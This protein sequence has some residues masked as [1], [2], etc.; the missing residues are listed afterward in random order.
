MEIL[1]GV[2]D[3]AAQILL[4]YP[5]CDSCL[6]RQFA[7]L[8]RGLSNRERGRAI[9]TLLLMECVR[10][11]SVLDEGLL[12]A[13][14]K[15]GFRPALEVSRERHLDVEV[16]R[17]YICNGLMEADELE[18]WADRVV[19]VLRHYEFDTFQL[20]CRLESEMLA[21]E[22]E[23]RAKFKLEYGES[24]KGE[25][26]REVGKLVQRRTGK[27]FDPRSPDVLA[28]VDV[29]R[30]RVEVEAR[31]LFVYGRYRKL[32][33]GIPQSV[34]L[35]SSCRGRGCPECNWTG[36]K[37]PDSIEEY[38]SLPIVEAAEGRG[39]KFHGAGREDLDV[40]TLGSG[41]P[42]V[43][44]VK[45]PRRRKLDLKEL[46][47]EI[48]KRAGGKVEVFGLR[49]ADRRTV[50]RIKR[51]AEI[52]TKVYR[53][54]ATFDREIK[55]EELRM[56]EDA[57]SNVTIKQRTPLRVLHRRADRVRSKVVYGVRA[58]KLGENRVE[59]LVECQGGLYVKEFVTGDGGRT[60]PSVAEILGARVLEVTVDVLGVEEVE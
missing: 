3:K 37:Y 47:E 2:L 60:R 24:I 43:V 44:E 41:R 21:R 40:R 42:F 58:R 13:L 49:F 57:L 30:G 20:G 46:E 5:L 1:R 26:N 54:I 52:S 12:K 27:A 4:E 8:G 14:A 19:E 55:E 25:F 51:L 48:N 9:K 34:W 10:G 35:C 50:R 39:Y 15:C 11:V 7:A 32:V 28:I 31:P 6:G 45:E 29:R 36:R 18:A 59:L 17:C 22:E 16:A 53:V 38:I 56:L 33:R 23:L